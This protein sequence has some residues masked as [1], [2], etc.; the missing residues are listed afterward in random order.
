MS[1]ENGTPLEALETGEV[2]NAADASRMAN[3]L[4]D[5]NASGA[6]VV[7]T[8][9]PREQLGMPMQPMPPMQMATSGMSNPLPPMM[10]HQ[11]QYIP[12]EEEQESYAPVRKNIWSRILETILDPLF[13]GILVLVLSLPVLHTVLGKYASWAYVLGGQLSWAGLL[14]KSLVAALLFGLYRALSDFLSA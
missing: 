12:V 9:V 7:S 2:A 11:P 4:R 8:N 14:V 3:I 10:T 13:V 1:V 5:M 6:D